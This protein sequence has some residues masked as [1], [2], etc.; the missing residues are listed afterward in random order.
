MRRRA[1]ASLAV[2]LAVTLLAFTIAPLGRTAA[3]EPYTL[4]TTATYAVDVDHRAVSVAID[5]KFTNLT[6]DPPGAFSVFSEVPIAIHDA[7]TAV[8]ARDG[9][10]K[11]DVR[12]STQKGGDGQPVNVATV[13][14]RTPLRLK[15]TA[16]FTLSYALPDGKAGGVRIRPSLVTFPV[17]SFGTSSAVNITLPAAYEVR[18][19]GDTLTATRDGDTT[20]L[21]SGAITNPAR[22]LAIITADRETAMTTA[23]RTVPLDGGTVDLNVRS[24]ADDAAWGTR[25]L[26][27]LASALPRLQKEIG[28]S[29]TGVGPLVVTETAPT[30]PS[31]LGE[32]PTRAAQQLEIA[33]DEAPFTV[34]H[35]AAHV[36][37]GEELV[38]DRWLREGLASHYAAR[39]AR[40]LKIAAPYEPAKQALQQE[41]AAFPLEEWTEDGDP[42]RAA[43]GYPASWAFVDQL[44]SPIGDDELQTVLRRAASGTSAYQPGTPSTGPVPATTTPINATALDSK[45]F[46][47]EAEDVSGSDL[48][49]T[50]HS[51]VFDDAS[52]ALL[53][54]RGPARTAY[55]DLLAAAGDWGAP[56]PVREAMTE[57]RFAE[58]TDQIAA[59]RNWLRERDD[60]IQAIQ[61]AGLS[62]PDRLRQPY[63]TAGG[64]TDA[65]VELQAERAVVDDYQAVL[66][67][68]NA[69]HSFVQRIG[70]LGGA[71]P[72]ELL[73]AAHGRFAEGDLRGAADATSE[74]RIRLDS[75]ETAGWLRLASAV[76]IVL[77]ALAAIAYLM[78]R[79]RTLAAN[80]D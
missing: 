48:T 45:R 47:D 77:V 68:A 66:D 34:L 58:A 71:A 18:S 46:L 43:Y 76:L 80:V 50:F 41:T 70:L 5:A 14:L 64:G 13:K 2:L 28:L 62:T 79:R 31:S 30:R 78:R 36:W 22:W 51:T 38:A 20:T 19:D 26:D 49:A 57:W 17:W 8:T 65:R 29:Y 9:S 61:R 35:Q 69:R 12:V 44:A 16:D 32:G 75:A 23:A 11:L 15:K 72:A 10:G 55:A 73:A 67:R 60:L 3:A 42:A 37:I 24:W 7:A 27:L 25:I 52:N 33:W 21:S 63:E 59:A 39:V 54:E 56:R 6:P 4:A 74:A 1:P 53:A 40:E